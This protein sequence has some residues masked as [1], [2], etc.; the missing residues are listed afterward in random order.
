MERNTSRDNHARQN[1]SPYNH[2][3]WCSWNY[4][5]WGKRTDNSLLFSTC[6]SRRFSHG[7]AF[8]TTL[9]QLVPSFYLFKGEYLKIQV[10]HDYAYCIHKWVDQIQLIYR[11]L[12][13]SPSS[14]SFLPILLLFSSEWVSPLVS[15]ISSFSLCVIR[16]ISYD[17]RGW[18]RYNTQW[19]WKWKWEEKKGRMKIKNE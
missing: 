6:Q 11:P 14:L 10:N 8:K 12:S 9:T 3:S 5:P 2:L 15:R 13:Y 19:K 4:S 18:T 17:L 7:S 16:R 1:I